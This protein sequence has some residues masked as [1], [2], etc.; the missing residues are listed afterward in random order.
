L[1][2]LLAGW[3]FYYFK[4]PIVKSASPIFLLI[5]IL[6][7]LLTYAVVLPMVKYV[8]TPE[9]CKLQPILGHLGFCLIFATLFVKT[10][11]LQSI[12]FEENLQP[13]LHLKDIHLLIRIL[14]CTLATSIYLIVW[15]TVDPPEP[16]EVIDDLYSYTVCKTSLSYYPNILLIAEG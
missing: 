11:R 13:K 3:V 12:F 16:T 7:F 9:I 2:T 15:L 8:P 1:T 5:M 14:V 6:G 4:H 10:H